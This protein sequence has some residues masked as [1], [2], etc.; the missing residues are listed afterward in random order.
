MEKKKS[1]SVG[2]KR[3]YYLDGAGEKGSWSREIRGI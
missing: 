3:L 1:S 2:Y